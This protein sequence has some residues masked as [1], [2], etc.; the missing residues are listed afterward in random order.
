LIVGPK[1]TFTSRYADPNNP[2]NSGDML[3]LLTGGK[4][5]M[6]PKGRG[7]RGLGA[8]GGRGMGMGGGLGGLGGFSGSGNPVGDRFAMAYGG[9]M[10]GGR[11]IGGYGGRGMPIGANQQQPYG[12]NQQYPNQEYP[13]P[14]YPNQQDPNQQGPNQ[15]YPNQQYSN[16]QYPNQ[17]YPNQ[18]GYN[19]QYSNQMGG[20]GGGMMGPGIDFGGTIMLG[21]GVKRILRHV[22]FPSLS[23][24]HIWR[25][26]LLTQIQR[27]LYLLIVN[28]PS[29]EEMAEA[30][31]M[32]DEAQKQAPTV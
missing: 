13:N 17:Q 12:P 10:G 4:L 25:A 1:P 7:F 29:D 5:S 28:M 2:S 6:P 18:M 9:G 19:Q 23:F 31:R 20:Y 32:M 8:F 24:Q 15:P 3:A 27:V 16:Q 21:E 11:G 22:S 30:T 14:Q 26:W